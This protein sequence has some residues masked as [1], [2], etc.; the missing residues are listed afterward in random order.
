MPIS[1]PPLCRRQLL[2]GSLHPAAGL[3][4][5][6]LVSPHC[7]AEVDPSRF[8]LLSDLHIDADPNH[9]ER[10]VNMRDN[11]LGIREELLTLSPQ[12]AAILICGDCAHH[13][14]KEAD[15]AE[16][17]RLFQPLRAAGYPIFSA[18]GNHDDRQ[19]FWRAL[20]HE[21]NGRPIRDRHTTVVETPLADWYVLDS[22]GV[23]NAIPGALG[24]AQ[25][26]WL[27]AA[28]DARPDRP[29]IVM[30]HHQPDFREEIRGLLDTKQLLEILS[31]RKQVKALIFGHTHNWHS[32][33]GEDGLHQINLPPTA[34]V[35]AD[36][37]PSGWVDV[38]LRPDGMSLEL[39][40]TDCN[41][42]QHMEKIDYRWR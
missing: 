24:D 31:P 15:Y 20:H 40:C 37:K 19:Q 23:T 32:V 7:N 38:K 28:L 2:T 8:V 17:V 13:W 27:A 14:G 34:Y 21:T 22:L 42:S 26:E 36:D 30:M 39:H 3:L 1:F 4:A 11:F 10:G 25:R 41:H 12:P 9:V 18:L 5:G 16:V 6:H 29:A 35:F 33:C